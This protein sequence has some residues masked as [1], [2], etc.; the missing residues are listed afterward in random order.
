ML[1]GVETYIH[2]VEE[3]FPACTNVSECTNSSYFD[4]EKN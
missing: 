1:C 4:V 2:R 3:V